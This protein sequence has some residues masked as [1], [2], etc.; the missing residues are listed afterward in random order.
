MRV[1]DVSHLP[2]DAVEALGNSFKAI[3]HRP[4]T[5]GKAPMPMGFL[6]VQ[7]G[8]IDPIVEPR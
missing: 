7:G 1:I 8:A 2:N 4:R 6:K 3:P 5:H